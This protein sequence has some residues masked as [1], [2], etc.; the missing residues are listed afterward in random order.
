MLYSYN[1]KL[2]VIY[3]M[4]EQKLIIKTEGTSIVI[5][6]YYRLPSTAKHTLYKI[7]AMRLLF[8]LAINEPYVEVIFNRNLRD[9]YLSLAVVDDRHSNRIWDT[10]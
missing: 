8:A 3:G 6:N 9:L 10:I 5:C 2:I 7:E 4:P 1:G